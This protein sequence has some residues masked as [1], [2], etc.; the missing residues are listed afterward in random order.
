M[1]NSSRLRYLGDCYATDFIYGPIPP[2]FQAHHTPNTNR[3]GPRISTR[4]AGCLSLGG[5]MMSPSQWQGRRYPALRIRV[6]NVPGGNCAG[7]QGSGA[8]RQQGVGLGSLRRELLLPGNRRGG[9]ARLTNSTGE[10]GQL[11]RRTESDRF[12]SLRQSGHRLPHAVC[13]SE[14]AGT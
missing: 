7:C 14:D 5:D 9:F 10:G 13:G 2:W 4:S 6:L 8:Y 3:V 11:G 12:V 1:G